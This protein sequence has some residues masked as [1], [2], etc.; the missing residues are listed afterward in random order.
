VK[1][2]A[3]G[4]A[5]RTPLTAYNESTLIV[6]NLICSTTAARTLELALV[7]GAFQRFGNVPAS[8]VHRRC[9]GFKAASSGPLVKIYTI[10]FLAENGQL[11]VH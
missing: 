3:R 6:I 8:Q 4:I 11:S 9:L 2:A 7:L 10:F 5:L 1:F